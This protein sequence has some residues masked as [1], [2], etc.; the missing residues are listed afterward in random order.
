MWVDVDGGRVEVYGGGPDHEVLYFESLSSIENCIAGSGDDSLYGGFDGSGGANALWGG[1]GNDWIVGNA[2]G[3]TLDGG[4]GSDTLFGGSEQ[5]QL[6][7][8]HPLVRDTARYDWA[9]SS[10]TATLAMFE[11]VVA[12]D[13]TD[14]VFDIENVWAGA[15]ADTLYGDAAD[16]EL[17][18]GAGA[19]VLSGGAGDDT[20]WGQSGTDVLDGGEG[21]DTAM[22]SEKTTPVRVDLAS[23]LVTY[24]GQTW[25]NETLALIES[26]VGGSGNDT[27]LGNAG[28]NVLRGGP[29]IDRIDGRGGLDTVSFASESGAVLIDLVAQRAGAIGGT[30]RDMLVSIE[31][32]RGGAG[33]DSLVGTAGANV[34]DG[35]N[36]A[37]TL[38]GGAGNDS[39]VLSLGTDRLDGGAGTNTLVLDQPYE[40]YANGTQSGV[41]NPRPTVGSSTGRA[42]R[43]WRST[44]ASART[45]RSSTA[46]QDR[47]R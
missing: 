25:A 18:G 22:F 34:L 21:S 45:R 5:W 37:D 33:N 12:G 3:D 4:T 40:R 8:I 28:S 31:N 41:A 27:L 7:D 47:Q 26:A 15:G 14:S 38:R 9:V 13:G 32:A 2:G 43:R 1:A 29:G 16:N 23:E 19:D 44:S 6:G 11:I 35:G 20:L 17:R 24:V 36:G 10:V 39:L 42:T 46:E 30:V